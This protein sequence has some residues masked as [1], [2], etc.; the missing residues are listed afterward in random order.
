MN[1]PPDTL[2]L[3]AALLGC[4]LSRDTAEG[5]MEGIIIETE[6]YTHDDPASHSFRGRTSRNASMFLPP[7][8]AYVYRSYGIHFCL[9]VTS[10]PEGTGE[11]VLVRALIP[12]EGIDLMRHHRGNAHDARLTQ[13]PGNLCSALA[14]DG[15]LDG[16]DLSNRP[17]RL[18][19]PPG[20]TLQE[21]LGT[22]RIGI[23]KAREKL[24]RFR[25]ATPQGCLL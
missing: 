22:P 11:A 5:I 21:P 15:S 10:G 13:G 16:H 8:H 3:A 20:H 12:T 17:L 4:I 24:W 7:F 2:S 9:N 1:L 19:V 6:A 23:T 18:F 14:I 25:T